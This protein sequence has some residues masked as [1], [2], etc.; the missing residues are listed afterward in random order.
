MAEPQ[1][2]IDEI[3][4]QAQS[5]D[6]HERAEFVRLACGNDETKL[7][8]VLLALGE[9]TSLAHDW[10]DAFARDPDTATGSLEGQRLGPYRIQRK[11]GSG[12]MGDVYLANRADDEYQQQVAIKL[13]R[14]GLFSQQVQS[15]LRMGRQI[16]ATL[17]Q[18][19]IA[20]VL[21]SGR[22]HFG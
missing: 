8:R 1:T 16:I 4:R 9:D 19:N 3:V 10:P 13:V 5:L 2:H 14:A 20:R 21:D 15:R 6:P 17:E 12:G 22:L 11:L 18:T 7:S